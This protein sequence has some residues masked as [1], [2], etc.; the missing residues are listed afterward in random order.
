MNLNINTTIPLILIVGIIIAII[1]SLIMNNTEK[2]DTAF[3]DPK[4]FP[5]LK[6]IEKNK[7]NITKEYQQLN[8]K[9]VPWPEKH[10][11]EHERDN[12]KVFPLYA[13]GFW[14]N[15][16]CQKMPVL[17]KF[18][19]SI[20][21]LKVA[22]LSKLGPKSKLESHKGWGQYSNN[23]VR[24]HFGLKVPKSCFM[25]VKQNDHSNYQ[26]QYHQEKKW[27]VFDDAKE[28]YACNNS[29]EERVILIIDLVRPNF[30]KRGQSDVK[31]S[32]ELAN[33]VEEFR[34]ASS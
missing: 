25:A 22:L 6:K 1:I 23:I 33:M 3:Y 21:N 5:E 31:Y 15:K 18:L 27:L 32:A 2:I 24:C 8:S 17:T 26:K 19:K 29:D 20:P 13:F 11:Y 7:N 34:K 16:N 4:M 28:H 14:V 10:L 9:W 30:I 12:W